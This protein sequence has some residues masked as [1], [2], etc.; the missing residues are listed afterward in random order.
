MA[1]SSDIEL[2]EAVVKNA[3]E[4]LA[5]ADLKQHLDAI[6][7][8]SDDLDELLGH[9]KR[10]SEFIATYPAPDFEDKR[11]AFLDAIEGY[12]L[13]TVESEGPLRVREYRA[14]LRLIEGGYRGILDM[15][16]RAEVSKLPAALRVSAYIAR[17][18]GEYSHV[19]KKA[20]QAAIRNGALDLAAAALLKD[21]DGNDYSPAAV[22]G[23]IVMTLGATLGMEAHRNKWWAADGRLVIPK[24]VP[25]TQDDLYKVGSGTVLGMLWRRWKRAE[26][27]HRFLEGELRELNTSEWPEGVPANIKRLLISRPGTLDLLDFVANERLG[28]QSEQDLMH[29]VTRTRIREQIVGIEG[30]ADLPPTNY[31]SIEEAHAVRALSNMLAF[32]VLS[33]AEER[34]G[35]TLAEWIRGYSLLKA[36]AHD[37]SDET[38]TDPILVR[39][40]ALEDALV[41][42]GLTA[43]RA[44]KFIDQVTF[45]RPKGATKASRDLYDCPLVATADGSYVL[46]APALLSSHVAMLTMSNVSRF[47][48]EFSRKGKA[49]EGYVHEIFRRQGLTCLSF[50]HETGDER[51]EFDAIVP[52]GDYVFLF[53]C[54]NHGLSG[55]DPVRAHHFAQGLASDMNQVRRQAEEL[56]TNPKLI[57][58]RLGKEWVGKKVI[59]TVLNCLP[60]A[61]PMADD[62][63]VLVSDVGIVRRFFEERYFYANQHHPLENKAAIL[64]RTAV[65]SQWSGTNPTPKD[66]L[67]ILRHPLQVKILKD[68]TVMDQSSYPIT[69]DT[70][71]LSYERLR[72]NTTDESFAS[73]AGGDPRRVKQT[74]AKADAVIRQAKSEHSRRAARKRDRL[75]R[76]MQKRNKV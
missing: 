40:E 2:S 46:I 27:K 60:Y 72:T 70:L 19:A 73:A 15:L 22:I 16:E 68:H 23:A 58:E 44:R 56:R 74:I 69:E 5:W 21:E 39:A 20:N 13:D 51:Y 30:S 53:E 71:V 66:F 32:D 42:V 37:L 65:A 41:R 36:M 47:G 63:D 7:F 26:E 49:F 4:K 38:R 12:A 57:A 43:E 17:S 25:T 8:D 28:Q 14:T 24:I 31:V 48:E 1:G 33:D 34:G 64:H 52:W 6:S 67:S 61:I 59:A 54:K 62:A 29:L 35:L 11:D 50:K 18:I 45:A 3:L 9:I 75:W 55:Y 10:H 76:E